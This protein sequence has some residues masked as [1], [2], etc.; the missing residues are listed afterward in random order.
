MSIDSYLQSQHDDLD[1]IATAKWSAGRSR[2]VT[3]YIFFEMLPS[4]IMGVLIFVAILLMFQALRLTEFVIVHSPPMH[5]VFDLVLYMSVSFLPAI[6]PMSLL[7][8]VLLTYG[9]LSQDSE[10][11]AFKAQGLSMVHLLIPAAILGALV[12]FFSAE[13]CFNIG[14]WGNHQ[15]EVLITEIGSTKIVD[16]VRSGTFSEGF[17]D[18][19][20]YANRVDS[21]ANKLE[22]VFIYD[23]REKTPLTIIAQEGQL[24]RGSTDPNDQS[25]PNVTYLKLSHGSVHRPTLDTYTKINFEH[26]RIALAM[27]QAGHSFT[28]KSPPS[29]TYADLKAALN[30]DLD[31][32]KRLT[33]ET[34]F[35]KRWAISFACLIFSFLGVGLGTVTNRRS[36]RS[37][38]FVI[39][40]V[41]IVIYWGLY[42]TGDSLARGGQVIPWLA[43]WFPNFLCIIAAARA[44]RRAWV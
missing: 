26:Y 14:P 37:S 20:V 44:L 21:K 36:A 35:H 13:T 40:L 12:S 7:F 9:R 5:V 11:V 41:V 18:L 24:T 30:S 17:F 1:H 34:E 8:S 38:G 15:F 42:V 43:V 6:L 31:K 39:S 33:L 23:G 19:V 16:A 10:I 4:F 27:P 25:L 32:E 29:L 28:E 22:D 3:R 2:T